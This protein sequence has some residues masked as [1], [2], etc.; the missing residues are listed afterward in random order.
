M[1]VAKNRERGRSG[2]EESSK[3]RPL[4]VLVFF[5]NSTGPNMAVLV[6][7]HRRPSSS[8]LSCSA[9]VLAFVLW[10]CDV[11]CRSLCQP[12]DQ[13]CFDPQTLKLRVCVYVGVC[14]FE[15]FEHECSKHL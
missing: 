15:L 6:R 2:R 8:R 5:L 14:L 11:A 12:F 7:A 13:R 9:V 3:G 4:V 1:Q 10:K